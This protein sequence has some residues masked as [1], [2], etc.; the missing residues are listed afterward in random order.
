MDIALI[1]GNRRMSEGARVESA[2]RTRTA[3]LDSAAN[4]FVE[5]GFGA[6]SLR[7]IAAQAGISHPG[8][9]RHF[10]SKD[11]ILDAVVDR[12]EQ[13]NREWVDAN[14]GGLEASGLELY[15][16]L[17]RHNASVP[18][19]TAL[20]TALGGEATRSGHPAH[21]RF[22]ERY[23]EIRSLSMAQFQAAVDDGLL[24][25]ETDVAGESIRLSAVWDGLQ[26]ISLYLPSRIDVAEM[27]RIHLARLR[28]VSPEPRA[29]TGTEPQAWPTAVKWADAL[30]YAPGRAR[31]AQIIADA[32]AL[33]ATRGFHAT[34]VREIAEKVGIGKSTLLHHFSSKEELLGAVIAHRD[35]T[36]D[37][38]VGFDFEAADPLTMLVDLPEA[39]RRDARDEPGLI[40][41]YAVL[42]AEAA[43]PAHPAH[44]YFEKRFELGIARFADLFLRAAA[45]GGLRPGLD[46]ETEAIWLIALWD[47]LQLQWLYDPQSVDVGD[48][49]AAHLQQLLA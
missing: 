38:R 9:L 33:F 45:D 27:F 4:L 19:Y 48:Q 11:E 5:Q 1:E 23:R 24:P 40:E 17:A 44:A 41:L 25:S 42:S 20:F 15:E 47:G 8:L 30:G 31:R 16:N 14:T 18:G 7:D 2:A 35:A 3:I 13:G 39:A 28:G 49:L 22:Q 32:S 46:P 10:A 43:A 34:S 6:V 36:L 21:S 37:E 26:L 12:L 29:V